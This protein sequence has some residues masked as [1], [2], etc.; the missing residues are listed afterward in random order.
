M[1]LKQGLAAGV[2]KEGIKLT[3]VSSI[4]FTLFMVLASFPTYSLQMFGRGSI[5]P[6]I[7]V[8]TLLEGI[9]LESG[10]LGLFLLILY[11]FLTGILVS[12]IYRIIKISGVKNSGYLAAVTPTAVVGACGACG[13]GLVAILGSGTAFA[14]MPFGGNLLRTL[15]IVVA[16]G[17]IHYLG[18]PTKCISSGS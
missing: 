1:K 18:D 12:N 7:A 11:G 3:I 17:T 15:G 13:A 4:F 8:Q 9:V 16:L 10:Y 2:S 14:L 5:Y 6:L